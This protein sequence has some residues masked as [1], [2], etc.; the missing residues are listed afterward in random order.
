MR[1]YILLFLLSGSLLSA[2][3]QVQ[4]SYSTKSKKAVKLFEKARNAPT[5]YADVNTGQPNYG[6]GIKL[7]KQAIGKAPAFWEAQ[8]LMGDRKSVV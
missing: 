7:L 1:I 6:E 2:C 8:L 4:M 5:Q 3:A